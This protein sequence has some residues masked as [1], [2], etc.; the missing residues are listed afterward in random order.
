[1]NYLEQLEWR[2]ACKRMNGNPVEEEKIN[3]I[4]EATR[5]APSSNGLQAHKILAIQNLDLR[6]KIQPICNNQAQILEC[7]LLL[8][9]CVPLHFEDS[10]VEDYMNRIAN[11]RK[12][13]I[14]SLDGFQ[15]SILKTIHANTPEQN[16]IWFA[17]QAYIALG[18]T[19]AAC[20]LESVDAC[21]M[22]GFKP[23]ELDKELGLTEIG[24]KSVVLCAIGESNTD[25]DSLATKKKIRKSKDDLFIW[26]K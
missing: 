16:Q 17:K 8:V 21:P 15:K 2:Y 6:K 20:A 22:E 4:L 7:S 14:S 13:E 23:T 10:Y 3:R 9:F 12:Q 5:L 18:F 24:L 11:E 1:M 26:Y 25:L 19:L